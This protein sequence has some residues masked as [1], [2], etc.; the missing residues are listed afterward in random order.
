MMKYLLK[1]NIENR[2]ILPQRKTRQNLPVKNYKYIHSSKKIRP[3]N[4]NNKENS[5]TSF[6]SKN[7]LKIK[8][9]LS[10]T[11]FIANL[12]FNFGEVYFSDFCFYLMTASY[13]RHYV[14]MVTDVSKEYLCM[15]ERLQ[16]LKI[17]LHYFLL[18]IYYPPLLKCTFF[19]YFLTIYIKSLKRQ[20]NKWSH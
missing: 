4:N 15:H 8:D 19:A 5:F 12:T 7:E 1:V 18:P 3:T 16:Y 9:H 11:G 17:T 13:Q 10:S 2:W 6:P 20:K 14:T